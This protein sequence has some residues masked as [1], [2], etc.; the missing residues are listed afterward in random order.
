[1]YDCDV[2]LTN[3]FS[4]MKYS[5]PTAYKSLSANKNFLKKVKVCTSLVSNWALSCLAVFIL[6]TFGILTSCRETSDV[7]APRS[8]KSRML[9]E[10]ERNFD[11][12]GDVANKNTGRIAGWWSDFI[13]FLVDVADVAI[14]DLEGAAKGAGIGLGVGVVIY[15]GQDQVE[16]RTNVAV[17]GAIIYGVG[18][19]IREVKRKTSDSLVSPSVSPYNSGTNPNSPDSSAWI[20][21]QAVVEIVNETVANPSISIRT[22]LRN[23]FLNIRHWQTNIVD[24]LLNEERFESVMS[25][26]EATSTHASFVLSLSNSG[27]DVEAA[28]IDTLY[29]D[30]IYLQNQNYSNAAAVAL[31]AAYKSN[32]TNLFI[33]AERKNHFRRALAIYEYAYVL[34]SENEPNW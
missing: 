20:H 29:S 10:V 33:N 28:Q 26:V 21:N 1:M 14:S 30:L 8:G 34:Y 24:S 17:A 6:I 18:A 12:I 25:D 22:A 9:E 7:V 23:H 13:G 19:S 31:F 32:V 11:P 16:Q 15:P 5:Q 2:C 27:L 4:A 3:L